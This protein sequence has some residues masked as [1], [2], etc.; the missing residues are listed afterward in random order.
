MSCPLLCCH[1][2][3]HT[4][5]SASNVTQSTHSLI[6]IAD[7]SGKHIFDVMSFDLISFL[8]LCVETKL[9]YKVGIIQQVLLKTK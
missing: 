2:G 8:S 7:K 9:S 3:C 6:H 4:L 5:A 1:A